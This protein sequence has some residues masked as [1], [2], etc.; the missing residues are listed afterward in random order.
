MTAFS[1]AHVCFLLATIAFLSLTSLLVAKLPRI[2]QTIAFILA[3]LLCA[4]GLFYRYAMHLSFDGGL[5]FKELAV[6]ML[7][8][9]NFNFILVGLVFIP[10]FELARQ[11]SV[12]FSMFAACTTFI[13]IPSAWATLHWYDATV[14]NFWL[15]HVFAVALPLWMVAARRLKPKKEYALKVSLCVVGYFTLSY[16][17]TLLLRH[18]GVVAQNASFSFIFDA[19]GN[20]LLAFLYSLIPVPYFY[21]L[22]LIPFAFLFFWG[23]AQLFKNY[24]L[25]EDKEKD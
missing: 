2:G 20:P 7:Q 9:C 13:S 23:L 24:R 11:Y 25:K 12:M 4:G 17:T 8:V 22:P 5:D 15:N 21:L 10:R 18:L 19:D 6:Q 1:T 14:V 16:L 3:A